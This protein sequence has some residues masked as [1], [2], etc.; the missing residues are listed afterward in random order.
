MSS[1][2]YAH[3]HPEASNLI[4]HSLKLECIFSLLFFIIFLNR[5]KSFSIVFNQPFLLGS[6]TTF[7]SVF[8]SPLFCF[9]VCL[10][11]KQPIIC[12]FIL[13][14]TLIVHPASILHFFCFVWK[15]IKGHVLVWTIEIFLAIM[16]TS[17]TV[18]LINHKFCVFFS[19]Y[20]FFF[21]ETMMLLFS[22]AYQNLLS[23][24]LTSCIPLYNFPPDLHTCFLIYTDDKILPNKSVL[25]RCWVAYNSDSFLLS[26]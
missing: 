26:K 2:C 3:Y 18:I 5:F 19:L 17:E 23:K 1:T 21:F 15:Y 16:S 10:F 20:Y 8:C 14:T 4:P 13:E 7:V 22:P 9:L 12:N 25:K 11:L 24:S 6:H